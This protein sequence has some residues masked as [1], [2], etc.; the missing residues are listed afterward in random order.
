M[1]DATKALE[2]AARTGNLQEVKRLVTAGTPLARVAENGALF[3]AALAGHAD[4]VA[5]LLDAG[6]DINERNSTGSTALMGALEQG[7]ADCVEV[8]VT[9]GAD[10]SLANNRGYTTDFYATASGSDAV[11]AAYSLTASAKTPEAREIRS[12]HAVGD[13]LLEEIYSFDLKE[14]V[15]YIRKGERGPVEAFT[16]ESFESLLGSEGLREAFAEHAR[17]GGGLREEDVAPGVLGKPRLSRQGG[18]P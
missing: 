14:R 13:R 18:A 16:R 15:T 17:R 12:V 10:K 4:C 11:R 8:L 3:A 7:K 2:A 5:F 9:R 6:A 1:T